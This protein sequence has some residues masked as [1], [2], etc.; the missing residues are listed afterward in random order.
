MRLASN[1]STIL[2]A[3]HKPNKIPTI[4]K[5]MPPNKSTVK[6]PSMTLKAVQ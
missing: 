4:P 1:L 5:P 6:I 2:L 3:I